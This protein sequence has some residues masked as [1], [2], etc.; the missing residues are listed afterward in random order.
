AVLVPA[1]DKGWT[2]FI[3]RAIE[4][5]PWG[6]DS[7]DPLIDGAAIA[8]MPAAAES[9]AFSMSLDDVSVVPPSVV[10]A[11]DVGAETPAHTMDIVP[12]PPLVDAPA[13]FTETCAEIDVTYE[14]EVPE[15]P[16]V[17]AAVHAEAVDAV[18]AVLEWMVRD[19]DLV[20][21]EPAPELE[22]ES[23]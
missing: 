23:D 11:V 1:R 17:E 10:E 4:D 13:S 22:P 7:E 8:S 21:S 12:Q 20:E 15:Q 9:A 19:E 5:L 18:D 6:D 14:D 2:G 16:P 3:L